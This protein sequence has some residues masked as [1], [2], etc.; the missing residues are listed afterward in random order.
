VPTTFRQP[1]GAPL[2]PSVVGVGHH[3]PDPEPGL[4]LSANRGYA[5]NPLKDLCV[6]PRVNLERIL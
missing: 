4:N 2:L 6:A 5:I 1:K 3:P